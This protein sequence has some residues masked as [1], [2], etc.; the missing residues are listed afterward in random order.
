[1]ILFFGAAGSGKSAQAQ[2]IVDNNGWSW[3]SMGQLFRNTTDSEVHDLMNKGILI[4]I[5]KTNQ[6]LDEA[7]VKFKSN[8]DKLILDGYPRNFEQAGW[9][10]QHCKLH[11]IEIEMAINFDVNME[12]LLRRM[13]LRGRNDDTPE[14]ISTRLAIYHKEIDPILDLLSKNGVKVV[15]IDGVGS[16]EDVHDRVMKE[17]VACKLA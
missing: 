15:H 9:L 4:P 3:L 17:L 12:E 8:A 11:N 16:F 2:M 10:M 13:E 6:I 14:S 7:L 1:M 5:E